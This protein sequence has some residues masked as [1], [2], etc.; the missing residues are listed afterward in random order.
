MTW[1]TVI[2][3]RPFMTE[4]EVK[5]AGQ[6]TAA[7]MASI[8][9]AI[10]DSTKSKKQLTRLIN[11]IQRYEGEEFEDKF[12]Q[13]GWDASDREDILQLL[14][15]TRDELSPQ[16]TKDNQPHIADK[17]QAF[18]DGNH[19]ALLE[20]VERSKMKGLA[21]AIQQWNKKNGDELREYLRENT[22]LADKFKKVFTQ[23]EPVGDRQK[24]VSTES[25]GDELVYDYVKMI[26]NDLSKVSNIGNEHQ[27]GK[28][29]YLPIRDAFNT[30]LAL[31]VFGLGAN[32]SGSLPPATSY[33]LRQE[34]IDLEQFLAVADTKT[35]T[36]KEI[37]LNR[38]R[39]SKLEG[40][41]QDTWD[42]S[43]TLSAFENTVA[44]NRDLTQEFKELM[45]GLGA[46]MKVEDV[47]TEVKYSIPKDA[48]EKIM[49]G[50]WDESLKVY[51][52]NS[53]DA[54]EEM[55]YEHKEDLASFKEKVSGFYRP[56]DGDTKKRLE[57]SEVLTEEGIE[58]WDSNTGQ[59]KELSSS[60][61]S[62][63]AFP[64]YLENLSKVESKTKAVIEAAEGNKNQVMIGDFIL[65]LA[66]TEMTFADR[67]SDVKR[68]VV[69]Y[70]KAPSEETKQALLDE[71]SSTKYKEIRKAM[72]DSI[73]EKISSLLK[74]YDSNY[75]H[76]KGGIEPLEWL[77]E[78][79]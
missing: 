54:L 24:E 10:E 68:A 52:I 2:K 61:V 65:Y 73:K 26:V 8:P 29:S 31:K 6:A 9:M 72:L 60:M 58:L 25:I 48:Y 33:I 62:G 4:D 64:Q 30:K 66:R 20:L 19:E 44:S 59:L 7:Q 35:S 43:E 27:M 32:Q 51:G 21:S 71:I 37:V 36:K 75:L 15:D 1:Q 45:E 50:H 11:K 70:A 39:N 28:A 77:W 55:M 22:E 41:L 38:L 67:D 78:R 34:D 74:D 23:L 12:R 3:A 47:T 40:A 17:I 63:K 53:D 46:E 13:A 16:P 76:E 79:L 49:A 14:K 57:N 18:L 69:G 5:F 56:V 42:A